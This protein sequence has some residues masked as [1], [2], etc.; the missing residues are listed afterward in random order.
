LRVA[1]PVVC[2]LVGVAISVACDEPSGGNTCASVGASSIVD[3]TDDSVFVLASLT[4]SPT[5]KVCWQNLG[6]LTHTMTSDNASIDGIDV[7]L[8]PNFTFTR[9]FGTQQDFRYHCRFHPGMV[10]LIQVR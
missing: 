5:Q 6:S 1:I 7:T 4:I 9:G 8:P 2:V 3:A 10:G